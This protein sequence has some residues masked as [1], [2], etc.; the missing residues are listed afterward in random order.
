MGLDR[1]ARNMLLEAASLGASLSAFAGGLQGHVTLLANTT[2]VT[3][4][5]PAV[6]AAFLAAHPQVSVSLREQAN[7]E[8]ARAVREGRADLGVVAGEIDFSV[9]EARHF[10]TDRLTLVCAP[11]HPL[12]ARADVALA[13]ALEHPSVGLYEGSTIQGILADLVEA[14][15]APAPASR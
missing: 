8:I 4:F 2:A 7:H 11:D 6:L 5:M 12:A 15:C 13:E 9:L 10:A 3:E 14:I 1:C